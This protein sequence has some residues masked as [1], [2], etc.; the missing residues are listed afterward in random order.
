MEVENRIAFLREEIN[1]YNHNYY[2]LDKS[3]I[4]DFEFDKILEELIFLEEKNL[5]FYDPL[6]PTQRVGNG[7]SNQFKAV[8][9]K[10]RMLS[11]GNT[12][13]E[14]D[15]IDFDNR[16][17]KIVETDIEYVCELKYDGVSIS[18]IYMD[19]VFTQALTRGDGF[20]GDD[21][22]QNIKT[23]KSIP[24]KLSNDYPNELE[25]RGEVFLPLKGFD[26]MNNSRVDLGLE[27]FANPRNAAS[28]SVKTLDSSEV[29][30]RPLDCFLYY[31]LLS[32]S[33][34]KQT[35][36][37][38][39]E[40]AKRWGF[41]V[42]SEIKVCNSI[43]QVIDFVNSW[44][45]KRH[46]LPYEIDGIVIKVNDLSI[47][48]QLGFT[49]KS[50]RWAISYKF[51]AEQVFTILNSVDYQVGRTGAITPVANLEPVQLAGTIVK[52]A[53][54]HNEDQINK[55]DLRLG[56]KVYV[57]KGG[58]IIPKVIAVDIKQR[59]LFSSVPFQYIS[60][61]PVCHSQ[62]VRS[63]NDAKHYCVN[64][65]EC[66]PQISGKIEHFV[67]RKA[68]NIDGLGSETI[69]LLIE[70]K[71]IK[72][73]I[74]LYSLK[75][76]Q[77]LPLKKNGQKWAQNIIEG[78][79]AS[80]QISFDKLLFGLGIRFVGATVSKVL[81]SHFK[82]IDNIM[83][84]SVEE[85]ENVDEIGIKIAQSLV[86]HFQIAENVNSI[87]VLKSFG[88]QLE[89]NKENNLL[90]EKLKDKLIVISGVFEIYS[91]DELKKIIEQHAG[92]NVA[93]ISKKTTFVLAGDKIGPSKRTKAESLGIP[94]VSES[95]FLNLI[96]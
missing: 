31:T 65:D 38:S 51:K 69:E 61:C 41:K 66:P 90:S 15:L 20:K 49:A 73:V 87:E 14:Q 17:K 28:G 75:L 48:D 84:A 54:L 34:Q 46:D 39:L 36:F 57:E 4:S 5:Q 45:D 80:K 83:N 71:L 33:E 64:S 94:F 26:K 96:S 32:K 42:P 74:D 3:L 72:S 56:D 24:L 47:Q 23:I 76:E 70:Q 86:N 93:S 85:L 7:L 2:V 37:Q 27:P 6:S 9:H 78:I 68:M 11:L 16:I 40:D 77:L 8:E 13:S 35:H 21:V 88:L 30:K 60:N 1:K 19:G 12:Y 52:R 58:E 53:S 81:V 18:L 44:D 29:A 10:H 22:S 82:N 95:E 91:R 55:L 25:I 79:I 92:K 67:S 62:L 63:E 50:P 43:G 89:L 59:D